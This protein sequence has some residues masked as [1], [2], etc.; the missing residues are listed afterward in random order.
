MIC[1]LLKT[2]PMQDYYLHAEGNDVAGN[3]FV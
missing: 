3:L 2:I 1:E